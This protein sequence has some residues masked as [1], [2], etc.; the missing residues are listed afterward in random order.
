VTKGASR[1]SQFS[2]VGSQ[3]TDNRQQT[4]RVAAG[5]ELIV[6]GGSLGGMYACEKILC[7]LPLDF[8]TPIA[9]AL[10]RHKKSNESLPE[11]FRRSCKVRITDAEDKQWIERTTVYLAPA[12]YHLLVEKGEFNLS[13]DEAVQYARPSIDVLFESAADA[14][15]PAVIGVILTGANN[16]GA[17]GVRKIK[18]HGGLVIAQD[19]RTA[20]SPIM[21]QAAIDTGAVDQILPLEKI[22]PF[23]VERCQLAVHR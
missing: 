3:T 23:L 9:I 19:P 5:Y 2:V 7:A 12:D 10:H 11:F 14:Y 17:A 15:G 22:G 13:V 18:S 8:E 21:P 20:E 6:I 1:R 16:D 4:T